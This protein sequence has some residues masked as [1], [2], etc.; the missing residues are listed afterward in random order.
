MIVDTLD[1]EWQR[2]SRCRC[3]TRHHRCTCLSTNFTAQPVI[4]RDRCASMYDAM[5]FVILK[6]IG[7]FELLGHFYGSNFVTRQAKDFLD[8]IY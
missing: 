2:S 7:C 8:G 3:W 1:A 5:L 6:S 4:Q